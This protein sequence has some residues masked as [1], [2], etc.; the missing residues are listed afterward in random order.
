M[1]MI[2]VF[3]GTKRMGEQRKL[4]MGRTLKGPAILPSKISF[5]TLEI[6][7][8]VLNKTYFRFFVSRGILGP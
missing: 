2:D 8:S 7:T 5:L 3:L 1:D 6:A 4:E